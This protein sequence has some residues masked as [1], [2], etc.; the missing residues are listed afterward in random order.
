[1][2][3]KLR[4]NRAAFTL[5]ELL[6]ALAVLSLLVMMLFM[7]FSNA[8][9]MMTLGSNQ[10][11]KNQVVRAVLQQ[12]ARDVERTVYSTTS[13]NIYASPPAEIFTGSGI[14]TQTLYCLSTLA[15]DE[16]NTN[17]NTLSVVNVGYQ[18]AQIPTTVFGS[19]VTKWALQ[20]G[21][22]SDISTV[23]YPTLWYNNW[24]A[25]AIANG[26]WKTLSDNIVGI[27]FQFYTNGDLCSTEWN[28]SAID[29]SNSLPQSVGI[30]IWA[31]DSANY[32]LALKFDSTAAFSSDPAKTI[33]TTNVHKYTSRVFLP[34]STKN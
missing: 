32:N 14:Y 33:F 5:I 20:R 17:T 3:N 28:S 34:Q 22:D 9:R 7:A 25:S 4:D 16:G 24:S 6:A 2:F 31:I 21:D 19:P 15:T 23:K 8:N 18:L 27:R 30:T 10:M 29:R 13:T 12:I 11:E 1:M 26:Y